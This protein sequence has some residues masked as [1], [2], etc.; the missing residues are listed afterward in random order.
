M[1]ANRFSVLILLLTTIVGCIGCERGITNKQL[2]PGIMELTGTLIQRHPYLFNSEELSDLDELNRQLREAVAQGKK[3][4][5]NSLAIERQ[6]NIEN[7][8]I[9]LLEQSD[10]VIRVTLTEDEVSVMPDSSITVPGESGALLLRIESKGDQKNC[11]TSEY[12]M[13][14]GDRYQLINVNLESDGVTWA[15]INLV[16]IPPDENKTIL[17]FNTKNGK[18]IK[19]PFAIIRQKLGRLKVSILSDDTGQPAPAMVRLIWKTNGQDQMP[20]NAIE[21][22][23]QL[24]HIKSDT[25][26]YIPLADNGDGRR[27]AFLPG[28]L[29]GH[30]WTVPAPFDMALSPG[31]WEITIR[32][33][34]EH[35]PIFDTFTV[36]S[37]QTVEKTYQPKRWVDM[38]K[39]GWYSGDTHVHCRILSDMDAKRLMAYVQAEDIHVANI[40]MMG[41]FRRTYF[42]QRGFGKEY[43]VIDGDYILAPGQEEPR[44]FATLGHFI[45]LNLT[46]FVRNTDYYFLYDIFADIIHEQGGLAGYAHANSGAFRVARDMSMNIPKGKIDFLEIFQGMYLGTNLYFDYLNLGFKL[47]ATAGSDIPWGHT[48]GD[49]RVYAFTGDQPFTADAWFEA[50]EK[51]RT[52]VTNGPML[53]FYVD[54]ALPGDEIEL[55]DNRKLHVKARAWG[56]PERIGAAPKKLEIIR[57]GEVIRSINSSDPNQEELALDF[58]IDSEFGFW[59]TARAEGYE[60]TH[61]LSSPIYVVRKGLRFWKFDEIDEIIDRTNLALDQVEQFVEETRKRSAENKLLADDLEYKQLDVLSAELLKRVDTAREIYRKLKEE[62]AEKE[63]QIRNQR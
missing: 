43:R 22:G 63:K 40:L 39:Y 19:L 37:G 11:I 1:K 8:I 25:T 6:A 51:G 53:E 46:D 14:N 47:T 13:A 42:E 62:T 28:R 26:K 54:D 31:E 10:S 32:R 57:H 20:S 16:R 36:E 48:I 7:R 55:T 60:G 4:T 56:S 29:L 49:V 52:F 17:L 38:R 23:E 59:I 50:F 44:T 27:P 12:N 35:I 45:G 3:D 41:N 18:T 9:A 33:G 61:A 58:E 30:Y 2:V 24:E 15:L 34:V 5:T 21:L